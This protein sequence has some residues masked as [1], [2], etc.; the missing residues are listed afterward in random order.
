MLRK[1]VPGNC[2]RNIV[3]ER[4]QSIAVNSCILLLLKFYEDDQG[5]MKRE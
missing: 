3:L 5:K 2:R 1:E 4:E